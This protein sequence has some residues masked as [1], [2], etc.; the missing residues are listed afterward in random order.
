[1]ICIINCIISNLNVNNKF[2]FLRPIN[3]AIEPTYSLIG[4]QVQV[5]N[6]QSINKGTST[7]RDTLQMLL[8]QRPI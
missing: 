4:I 3:I 6:F 8:I 7:K 5:Y 1:M 2:K